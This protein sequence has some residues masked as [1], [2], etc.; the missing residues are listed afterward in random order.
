MAE[1]SDESHYT[2]KLNAELLK[3][4]DVRIELIQNILDMMF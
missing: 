4:V 3:H 2:I 1:V